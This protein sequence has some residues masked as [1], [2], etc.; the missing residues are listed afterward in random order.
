MASMLRSLDLR[1]LNAVVVLANYT[2][3]ASRVDAPSKFAFTI[4]LQPSRFHHQIH[5]PIF[6]SSA[7]QGERV[8]FNH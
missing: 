3:S 4:D 7:G 1:K 8:S 2:E 5:C 6:D